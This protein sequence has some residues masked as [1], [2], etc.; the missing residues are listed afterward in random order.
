MA[1]LPVDPQEI[2]GQWRKGYVL[3]VHTTRSE[4]LGDDEFG[5]QVFETHR[6]HVGESLYRLKYKG[7]EDALP[8]LI[9][10]STQFVRRWRV[11][12]TGIVPV[13]ATNYR[14]RVQPVSMLAR[15]LGREL[16]LP[17]LTDAVLRT[18]QYE[19]LKNVQDPDERR[20]L[21]DGAFRIRAERVRG[22]RLLLVDDLYRSGATMKVLSE[23][24]TV[25]GAAAVYAYALTRTRTRS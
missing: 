2:H 14:R 24:L 12:V 13:P 22:E 3:D 16:G 1:R 6:T 10:T 11:S 19:E 25:A 4:Y 17:V 21:L 15:G 8:P 5:H 7:D 23:A 9:D 20:R 18:K